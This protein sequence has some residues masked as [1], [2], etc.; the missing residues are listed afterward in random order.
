MTY[1]PQDILHPIRS[2]ALSGM[3]NVR[4][5]FFTR[6]GG[7]STGIYAGLNAGLGSSDEPERVRENR[8]RIASWLGR[9]DG[10]ISTP[11]QVHSDC[12]VVIDRPLGE[13][14]RPKAD[15]LVTATPGVLVGV[16]TADCGP[17][18]FADPENGVVAAAHSGWK[19]A[20]SGII[21]NTVEA[22]ISAG[23][24]RENIH[25]VLGPTIGP[26]NYEVGPEFEAR[27]R[28]SDSGNARFFRPSQR[29]GHFL[30][31]LPA[32]ILSRLAAAGI[33]ASHTGHCTYADEALFYSYRRTTHRGE[34]D[35]GRQLS[36]I[37]LSD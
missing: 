5:G 12:A 28:A 7:V 1:N 33:G 3:G 26:D 27:F 18:L 8:A 31:D 36:A 6:E 32:Y 20:V 22:M 11:H 9:P 21:E 25:A 15:A 16:L 14:E 34:P 19:G 17:V 2:Q 29:D 35:Y 30:F 13:T 37:V 23:A 10:A 24:R 4:H